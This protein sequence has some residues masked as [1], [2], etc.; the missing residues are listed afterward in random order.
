MTSPIVAHR[1]PWPSP[2][3]GAP[4][5][6]AIGPANAELIVGVPW[7]YLRDRYPSL[8]RPI[9]ERKS[10]ILARDL[11]AALAGRDPRD[12]VTA[13]D[14]EYAASLGLVTVRR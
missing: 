1:D 5:P 4:L 10:V 13:A 6:L 7:R 11:E 12:E 9:G 2:P 14:D 8:L 3:A